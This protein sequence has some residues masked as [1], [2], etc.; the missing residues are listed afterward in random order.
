MNG[1]GVLRGVGV[2]PGDPELMT[3]RSVALLQASATIA[4]VVDE[5]GESYARKIAA[6]FF[7]AFVHEV[8][9]FFSMSLDRSKRLAARA[10]AVHQVMDLL[11][12]GDDVTFIAEGDPLLYSTFQY[13]LSGISP[14]VPVEICPGISAL[15]ASAA[16][17]SF[18]LLTE[19]E[20]MVVAT[21]T[22]ESIQR[23]PEWLKSFDGIVFFKVHR[24]MADLAAALDKAQYSG[25]TVLVQRASLAGQAMVTDLA[26][27]DRSPLPYFTVA[28]IRSAD[29]K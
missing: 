3:L 29:E 7:P 5:Q 9:L 20:R 19:E 10:E 16:E 6:G 2:G 22:P 4:Y 14:Q 28:L 12:A 1:Y 24:L 8:P 11:S 21:L 17:A 23:L 26:D 27:W 18:P 25:R 15:N 13:L